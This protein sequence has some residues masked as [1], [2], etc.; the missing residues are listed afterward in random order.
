ML[1]GVHPSCFDF[2]KPRLSNPKPIRYSDISDEMYDTDTFRMYAFKIQRCPRSRSHDWTECPYAHRG[3]KARRRDPRKINYSAIACPDFRDGE[4]EKGDSCEFAH[5][6][7]EFWLHPARYRTRACNAGRY[8]QR[9]VCFFAHTPEQLRSDTN[10]K[11]QYTY[12]VRMNSSGGVD[13]KDGLDGGKRNLVSPPARDGNSVEE[14]SD[15]EGLKMGDG[16]EWERS[17]GCNVSDLPD[18]DWIVE[19]VK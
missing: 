18:I 14:N 9:K 11:C 7:F 4:C 12:R 6:V 5:G 1:K 3:E 17:F 15:F 16:D 10:H 19:L 13:N 8:C 2:S